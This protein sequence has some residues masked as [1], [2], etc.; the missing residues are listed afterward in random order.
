MQYLSWLIRLLLVFLLAGFA[1][2][3]ADVVSLSYFGYSW[4]APL[5]LI[6]LAFFIGGVVAGLLAI[7]TTL[8]KQQREI[9]ALKRSAKKATKSEEQIGISTTTGLPGR[10]PPPKS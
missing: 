4:R 10:F 6:I 9:G 1:F 2:Q 5:V 8:Y 7:S 3:N